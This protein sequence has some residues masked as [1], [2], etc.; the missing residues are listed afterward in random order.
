MTEK[1]ASKYLV[2]LE[3]HFANDNP[4][5][6]K[7]AKVFHDLDQIEYDLGLIEMD[8]TTACK[9]S[10]WPII[11]LIGGNSSAKS[12]FINSYLGAQQLALRYS[13]FQPQIYCSTA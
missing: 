13:T 10:W 3:K 9:N 5:L 1:T 12:R 2:N 7:S 8:D 6:L 4:V 11:S